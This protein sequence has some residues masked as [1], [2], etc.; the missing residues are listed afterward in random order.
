M[1]KRSSNSSMPAS[2][3]RRV[4][5]K[6][7][8]KISASFIS[9]KL[10]NALFAS[11]QVDA[12]ESTVE[13]PSSHLLTLAMFHYDVHAVNPRHFI[14]LLM[15]QLSQ[16]RNSGSSKSILSRGRGPAVGKA[17]DVAGS[18]RRQSLERPVNAFASFR[19]LKLTRKKRTSHRSSNFVT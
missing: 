18:R 17:N 8:R 16:A 19:H 6:L 2:T 1:F 13:T 12:S 9:S 14:S 7:V 10:S 4:Y 5:R 15:R 3:F 11:T